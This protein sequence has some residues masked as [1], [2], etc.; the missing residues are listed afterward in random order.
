MKWK[1]VLFSELLNKLG[2][3]IVGAKWKGR[4]YFR[5]YVIPANPRTNKQE[6][7]RAIMA[8]LV[9]RCQQVVLDDA[10]IKSAWD[11]EALPL[12]VS[13]YNLFV[14]YGRLSKIS[15]PSTASAGDDITVTYTCGI[16]LTKAGIIRYDGSSWDTVADKGTLEDGEDKTVTDSS[17]PAGTYYYYLADMNVLKEG[18][19]SPQ[20]YQAITD[21]EPDTTNGVATE[22]KC[23]VS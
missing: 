8:N 14:K 11:T 6:A 2:D 5:S 18:D 4:G 9:K 15:V 17:V 3:Q 1:S 21:W 23:V 20:E 16:P 12:L 13:G 10:D 19:S 22:A 7:H